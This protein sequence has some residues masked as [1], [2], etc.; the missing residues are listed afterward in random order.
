MIE[1]KIEMNYGYMIC[2]SDENEIYDRYEVVGGYNVQEAISIFY[3]KRQFDGIDNELLYK[4]IR[5][6]SKEEAVDVFNALVPRYRII[7]IYS[8][9]DLVYRENSNIEKGGENV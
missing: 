6:L 5:N 2:F 3:H 9:A 1:V 8:I 7:E 4:M